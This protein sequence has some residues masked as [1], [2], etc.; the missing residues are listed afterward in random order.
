MKEKTVKGN[1]V[2]HLEMLGKED[3]A[4]AYQEHAEEWQNDP[5]KVF[6]DRAALDDGI[7][8]EPFDA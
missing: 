4:K 7:D 1:L 6:W 2:H 3:L 5:D 8:S